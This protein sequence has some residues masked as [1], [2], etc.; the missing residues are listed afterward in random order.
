M[1]SLLKTWQTSA[2]FQGLNIF[3]GHVVLLQIFHSVVVAAVAICKWASMAGLQRG[4]LWLRKFEFICLSSATKY[5]F[6]RFSSIW[7]GKNHSWF[8]G[9]TE[10][11][12]IRPP[13]HS[14]LLSTA[15]GF[16]NMIYLVETY[17]PY[18][19]GNNHL[20][21]TLNRI[22][23]STFEVPKLSCWSIFVSVGAVFSLFMMPTFQWVC[24]FLADATW[25]HQGGVTVE[26]QSWAEPTRV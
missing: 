17:F 3:V 11:D 6:L 25:Q 9:L 21:W 1:S 15:A 2:K 5:Y 23:K 10:M 26:A 22:Q 12:C 16:S 20:D 8:V 14:L 24:T 4:Y 13:S 18:L 19:E 7:K